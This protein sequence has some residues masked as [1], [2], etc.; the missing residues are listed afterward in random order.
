MS[1]PS[2]KSK[3]RF[4]HEHSCPNRPASLLPGCPGRLRALAARPARCPHNHVHWGAAG[5]G[6]QGPS[7][8]N[9]LRAVQLRGGSFGNRHRSHGG[10]V[11]RQ[12]DLWGSRIH[13]RRSD[14]P[15]PP[16]GQQRFEFR[17]RQAIHQ[18]LDPALQRNQVDQLSLPGIREYGR[19]HRRR[20]L[21]QRQQHR[22]PPGPPPWEPRHCNRWVWAPM[23]PLI[24]SR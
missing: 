5:A 1:P 4:H 19:E 2:N 20:F 23:A 9:C 16:G 10:R 3:T 6:R 14:L 21:S 24:S 8:P 7:R 17:L 12:L 15:R 11:E 22:P 13:R 18:P